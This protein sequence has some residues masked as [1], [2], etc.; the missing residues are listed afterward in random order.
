MKKGLKKFMT[1]AL[2][3]SVMAFAAGCSDDDDDD[4]T[5]NGT[6]TGEVYASIPP[7]VNDTFEQTFTVSGS[8]LSISLEIPDYQISLPLSVDLTDMTNGSLSEE[9]MTF[10]GTFFNMAPK[11]LT[12][13]SPSGNIV[14][15][16]ESDPESYEYNNKSYAGFCAKANSVTIIS[17]DIVGTATVPGAPQALPVSIYVYGQR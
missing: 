17:L 10:N 1:L 7:L 13:P 3:L 2:G 8:K 12:I 9:G 6:Y 4:F 14:I 11:T 16:L 5:M 15:A